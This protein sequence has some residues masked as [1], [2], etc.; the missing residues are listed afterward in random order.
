MPFAAWPGTKPARQRFWKGGPHRENRRA[1]R[2]RHP[3][4]R[5]PGFAG[6]RF[7]GAGS[8]SEWLTGRQSWPGN[9]SLSL[10]DTMD[11]DRIEGAAHQAKGAVKEGIGKLTGDTKTKA[12]GTAEKAAGKVQNAVGGAKDA[13]R[14]A[15]K[16]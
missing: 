14:D 8:Q 10:E 6:G 3:N 12:E 13:V 5:K 11:K 2:D 1:V 15:V 16:K 4:D 7:E 9:R